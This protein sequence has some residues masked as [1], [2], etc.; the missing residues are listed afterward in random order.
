MYLFELYDIIFVI[1]SL[2]TRSYPITF[3]I[4]FNFIDHDLDFPT[5]RNLD[6]QI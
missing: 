6:L 4:S 2:R 1:K 5:P 3:T